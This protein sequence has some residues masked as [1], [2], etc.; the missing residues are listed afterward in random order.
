[1]TT[2]SQEQQKKHY[3]REL[4]AYTFRQWTAVQKSVDERS[5]ASASLSSAMRD[6][7]LASPGPVAQERNRARHISAEHGQQTEKIG[8]DN[9]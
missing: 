9:S 5:D 1:M 6:I 7:S 3:S 4:A 8:Q 2:Q